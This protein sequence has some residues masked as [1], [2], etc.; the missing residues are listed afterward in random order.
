[1]SCSMIVSCAELCVPYMGQYPRVSGVNPL[2]LPKKL[3]SALVSR[4][5]ARSEP[6]LPVMRHTNYVPHV[7]EVDNYSGRQR[8]LT[9]ARFDESQ[10][11]THESPM[12]Q[13]R[14]RERSVPFEQLT[15]Y[16]APND[17]SKCA[18]CSCG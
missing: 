14:Q 9:W 4:S 8:A 3:A 15:G 18:R 6:W 7:I 2:L 17:Q 13:I 5:V 12:S 11:E 1:L 10:S 16:G